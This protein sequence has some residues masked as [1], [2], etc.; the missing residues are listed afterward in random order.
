MHKKSPVRG[1]ENFAFI[2]LQNFF[3]APREFYGVAADHI[4]SEKGA[5]IQQIKKI[6]QES[7]GT[8]SG[9]DLFMIS[10]IFLAGKRP[11]GEFQ[12]THGAAFRG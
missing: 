10:H 1:G 3:R 4:G 8:G 5:E 7:A 2:L 11:G 9:A 6:K 12:N